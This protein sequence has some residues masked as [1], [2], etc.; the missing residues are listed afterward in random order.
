MPN[1]GINSMANSPW[2]TCWPDAAAEATGA[3][4]PAV[5]PCDTVKR[6][7]SGEDGPRVVRTLDRSLLRLVQ[8]PQ[9]LGRPVLENAYRVLGDFEITD[10][11]SAVEMT[12]HSVVVIDGEPGNVKI[13]TADDLEAARARSNLMM[14]LEPGARIGE[15]FFIDH[16]TGVVIGETTIIGDRVRIYQG[17]TLGGANFA[18]DENGRLIRDHKRH[19]TIEDDCVIYAGAT[20]LGGETQVGRGSV[21]GGN[22]WLTGSIPAGTKVVIESPRLQ[23]RGQPVTKQ[24]AQIDF[25]I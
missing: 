18:K 4:V 12:G 9:G 6:V 19:P 17:V 8:T 13:T 10:D 15:H 23:Y 20:I 14:G 21:V 1:T 7:E 22:V 5:P 2:V 11:A 3:C 24:E 16:G 25:Q